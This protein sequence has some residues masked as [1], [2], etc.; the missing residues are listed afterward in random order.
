MVKRVSLK[1]KGAELFFGGLQPAE[2]EVDPV[3]QD[4]P[5]S[6]VVEPPA[7]PRS[8]DHPANGRHRPSDGAATR[9]RRPSPARKTA[10]AEASTLASSDGAELVETVRR[11]VKTLGKEVSF[12]RLT[13]AEKEELGE[14]IYAFKQQGVK[15]TENEINRIAINVILADHRANGD[16]SLLARVLAALRA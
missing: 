5:E 8:V 6:S 4:E 13:A 11:V 7:S 3:V 1:G 12:V 9:P 15:T 2:P 14:L 10:S 16:A